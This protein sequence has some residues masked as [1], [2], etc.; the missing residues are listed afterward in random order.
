[1]L[2][3]VKY[4]EAIKVKKSSKAKSMNNPDF[5]DRVKLKEFSLL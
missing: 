1:M 3:F 4:S 2:P 5:K